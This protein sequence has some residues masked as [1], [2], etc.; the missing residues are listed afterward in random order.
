MLSQWHGEVVTAGGEVSWKSR[1]LFIFIFFPSDFSTRSGIFGSMWLQVASSSNGFIGILKMEQYHLTKV[2]S[3]IRSIK[4]KQVRNPLLWLKQS[5]T[6][7]IIASFKT[8]RLIILLNKS[9]TW[10]ILFIKIS[11]KANEW[12][13]SK[14]ETSALWESFYEG[15]QWKFK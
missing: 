3:I 7:L 6:S 12:Q 13:F 5:I 15:I 9:I 1:H 4:E 8:C 10:K 2:R 14:L 11:G